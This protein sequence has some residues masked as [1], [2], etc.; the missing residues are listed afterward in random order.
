[1]MRLVVV[2]DMMR[3]VVVAD[4]MRLVV[5]ADM[6]RLVVL[7][8]VMCLVVVAGVMCLVPKYGI[9]VPVFV[10]MSNQPNG[11]TLDEEGM[12]LKSPNHTFHMLDKI[13]VS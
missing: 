11:Y 1:M 8:S 10:P 2:A 6:M 13:K 3:L 5:V 9:E 7:T 12:C 4:M